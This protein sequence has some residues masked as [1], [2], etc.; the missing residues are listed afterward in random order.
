MNDEEDD[1]EED[2]EEP[3]DEEEEDG[4]TGWLDTTA[5]QEQEQ[6]ASKADKVTRW[7]LVHQLPT[8]LK[9]LIINTYQERRNIRCLEAM[10]EG[11]D[12]H[13]AVKLPDLETVEIYIP[14]VLP[15]INH[16]SDWALLTARLDKLV[17]SLRSVKAVLHVGG[18]P[19]DTS[20]SG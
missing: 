15:D 7:R 14:S 13:R 9:T 4:E 20:L 16:E 1:G 18:I 2:D 11:F 12:E 19:R 6:A 10:F 17:G 3:D 8:T 5:E